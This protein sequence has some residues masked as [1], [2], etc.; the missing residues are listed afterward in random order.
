MLVLE[1]LHIAWAQAGEHGPAVE[2]ALRVEY[3]ER[4]RHVVQA[5]RHGIREVF[6]VGGGKLSE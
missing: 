4:R 5:G 3:E 6:L 2:S 1:G